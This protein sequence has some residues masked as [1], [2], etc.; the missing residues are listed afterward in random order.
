MIN[1]KKV[2]CAICGKYKKLKNPKISFIF[3]KTH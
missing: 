3:E 2:S 1:M